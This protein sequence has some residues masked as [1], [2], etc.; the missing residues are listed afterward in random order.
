MVL[1]PTEV[2]HSNRDQL[3]LEDDV[4]RM[5]QRSF[6]SP[7]I[8]T[9]FSPILPKMATPSTTS[10]TP[11]QLELAARLLDICQQYDFSPT[12]HDLKNRLGLNP[13]R[14]VD[15]PTFSGLSDF[16]YPNLEAI[17]LKDAREFVST[18][19]TRI[20]PLP[21]ELLDQF[22]RMQCSCAMGLFAEIGRAWVTVDSDLFVWNYE[23]K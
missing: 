1:R 16:D 11:E 21:Q 6:V 3:I 22:A 23:T 7:S 5:A 19:P 13:S 2:Q 4:T 17:G 14:L 12:M 10:A 15:Q 8:S 18:S 9:I 20:Q